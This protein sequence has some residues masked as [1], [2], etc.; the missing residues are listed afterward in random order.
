MGQFIDGAAHSALL[1]ERTK[2]RVRATAR[3]L[4]RPPRLDV[5][6]VGD[7]PASRSYVSTKAR[8]AAETGIDGRLV[9]LHATIAEAE[10][11]ARIDELNRDLNVDG[12]LVQLPLP[13][14]IDAGVILERIDP[15]KDVDGFHPVNAG[16]LAIAARVDLDRFLIPCTPL[17]CLLML[18]QTLGADGL[19][20]RVAI[21]IGRS[22]IV[23]KPMAR[24]L[25][26][27]DCTVI[28]AH[29]ATRNLPEFS[30]M[31][32]I[33]VVAVG[34]PE[35][36]RGDWV[37]PGATVIDVGINRVPAPGGKTKLVGDVLTA[38]AL[39]RAAF[40]T[41]VP[42]GVGRMTV[43]CLLHNTVAAAER[44]MRLGAL[45]AERISA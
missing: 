45:D 20:G 10:L 6:I 41:P 11:I 26:A 34:R 22:N 5:I 2:E 44:R 23:G 42:G 13:A 24:L 40:V 8:Q 38:E 21:V 15:N 30:R 32:D 29:S 3:R 25:A 28:L 9:E 37:K 4:G 12:I 18:R 16:R 14:H 27:S 31:A 35:M 39:E 1:H 17:G 43:A 19:A 33:L 7:D 36:V